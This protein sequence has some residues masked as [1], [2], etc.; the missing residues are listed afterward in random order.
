MTDKPKSAKVGEL[1]RWFRNAACDDEDWGGDLVWLQIKWVRTA[2]ALREYKLIL[3]ELERS[4]VVAPTATTE[5]GRIPS[6]ADE[7]ILRG[8]IFCCAMAALG[9]GVAF[10]IYKFYL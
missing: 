7:T 4:A 10:I 3:R 2:D 5:P 8:V 1:E 9:C 6:A